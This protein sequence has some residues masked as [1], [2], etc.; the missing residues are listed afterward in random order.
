MI[1]I[2]RFITRME[3]H[4]STCCDYQ[5]S[6]INA[7]NISSCI[8]QLWDFI[9]ISLWIFIWIYR[10]RVLSIT[11]TM[12]LYKVASILG[13]YMNRIMEIHQPNYV[14]PKIEL[15]KSNYGDPWLEKWISLN[16]IMATQNW[17]VDKRIAQFN[18]E[19]WNFM[20]WQALS[21]SITVLLSFAFYL[22]SPTTDWISSTIYGAS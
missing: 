7:T 3:I 9:N 16:W 5:W 12:D 14:A 4:N 19:L 6:S 15:H 8:V 22:R 18:N 13:I 11:P 20:I 1:D 17:I 10:D 2:W 21:R